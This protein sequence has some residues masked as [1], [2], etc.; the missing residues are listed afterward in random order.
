MGSCHS[1]VLPTAAKDSSSLLCERNSIKESQEKFH[2]QGHETHDVKGNPPAPYTT[3]DIIDCSKSG[4]VPTLVPLLGGDG[5]H[6]IGSSTEYSNPP[7]GDNSTV[8]DKKCNLI[9]QTPYEH[10]HQLDHGPSEEGMVSWL[11]KAHE[12]RTQHLD[13]NESD[14]LPQKQHKRI[15]S[16]ATIDMLLQ[17]REI[18]G[19]LRQ[20]STV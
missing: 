6:T 11:A 19:V 16:N 18:L 9:G 1:V 12:L 17:M 2:Q 15:G 8:K 3:A 14:S 7:E 4:P 5:E 13:A 10:E 20:Y